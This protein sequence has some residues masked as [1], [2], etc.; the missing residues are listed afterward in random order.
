MPSNR[1]PVENVNVELLD[2]VDSLVVQT[3]TSGSD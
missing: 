2:D 3:K 1:L